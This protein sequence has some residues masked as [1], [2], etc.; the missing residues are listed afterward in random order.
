VFSF[1]P[2]DVDPLASLHK[3]SLVLA[4]LLPGRCRHQFATP[5]L[6]HGL[7][8]EHV[9]D[10]PIEPGRA[11]LVLIWGAPWW[12]PQATQSLL[13][14]RPAQRP[15][16]LIWHTEPLPLPRAAGFPAQRRSLRELAKIALRDAR[17]ADA[18]SNL[19][20]LIRL[21]E[22]G[23]PDVLVVPYAASAETL[24][25]HG[26]QSHVVPIGS[27]PRHCVDIG[28]ERD[29]DV[30]FLGALEVPRRR[31]LLRRLHRDGVVV[32]AVGGWANQAY[33]GA[34][35]TELLNRT[36]ILLNLGR[37][38]GQLSGHRF[39]LGMGTGAV[40][41][42]EPV[43]RPDPFVPGKHYVSAA[44]DDLPGAIARLLDADAQRT[45]IATR[46]RRFVRE[47][48]TMERSLAQVAALVAQ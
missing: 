19:Q 27:G 33:W 7:P 47:E 15:H 45:A 1:Q 48:L 14:M 18:R 44:L 9:P 6:E 11:D 31:R 8:I 28:L 25:E 36:K 46:A 41:A 2:M 39:V 17:V 30:T 42:S 16:V 24:A 29:I 5:L 21:G 3:P 13:R 37:F 32:H 20:R 12:Y 22:S 23:V 26:L 4:R 35:R 34:A 43:Y 40:L 38:P 10:G